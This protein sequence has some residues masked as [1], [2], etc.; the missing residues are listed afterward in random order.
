MIRRC[1]DKDFEAIW[2]T[3]ND[4]AQAYKGLIP[5]G[6]WA[7]QETTPY[8]SKE[9]LQGELDAGVEF[10][11]VEEDGAL[12]GVMGMQEVEDV[13]LIRHAYVRSGQ[14]KKGIGSQLLSHLLRSSVNPVLVGTWARAKGAIHFYENRS[15]KVLDGEVKERLLRKYWKVPEEQM[16][17][18]V[19]LADQKWMSKLE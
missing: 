12:L 5:E 13:T 19:V 3:I 1:E 2:E 9:E 7:D 4:G 16:E 15:F 8:M 10:W 18:S 14:Q 11:T 6:R 17:N